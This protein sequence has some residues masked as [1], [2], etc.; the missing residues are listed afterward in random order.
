MKDALFEI[1]GGD[2]TEYEN[3]CKFVDLIREKYTEM[4]LALDLSKISL[5]DDVKD[6]E[7]IRQANIARLKGDENLMVS[8]LGEIMKKPSNN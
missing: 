7:Q 4:H 3:L 1:F 5:K 8:L 6:E 2:S